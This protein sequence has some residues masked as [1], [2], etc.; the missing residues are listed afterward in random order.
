MSES[1]PNY[2][3]LNKICLQILEKP[4]FYGINGLTMTEKQIENKAREIL[5]TTQK[6]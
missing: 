6:S 2:E 3:E 5:K 1:D 4:S